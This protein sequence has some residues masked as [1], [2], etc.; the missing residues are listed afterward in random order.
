MRVAEWRPPG[1]L[2]GRFPTGVGLTILDLALPRGKLILMSSLPRANDPRLLFGLIQQWRWEWLRDEWNTIGE[3]L[4]G[5]APPLPLPGPNPP[6]T[7]NVPLTLR[8]VL[9][10]HG[11]L[12]GGTLATREMAMRRI[13]RTRDNWLVLANTP[14]CLAQLKTRGGRRALN[15]ANR[16]YFL[17]VQVER[18]ELGRE[19]MTP[20]STVNQAGYGLDGWGSVGAGRAGRDGVLDAPPVTNLRTGR[21]ADPRGWRP[22]AVVREAFRAGVRPN[23]WVAFGWRQVDGNGNVR[24][25]VPPWTER[26]VTG[27][28]AEYQEV[29]AAFRRFGGTRTLRYYGRRLGLNPVPMTQGLTL[30]ILHKCRQTSNWI[31]RAVREA[32]VRIAAILQ[33]AQLPDLG[34]SEAF[35]DAGLRGAELKVRE[36]KRHE[37]SLRKILHT[38]R[39]QHFRI[40]NPLLEPRASAIQRQA[41]VAT[42]ATNISLAAAA[43]RGWIPA[44]RARSVRLGG[45]YERVWRM[46][47]AWKAAVT[48]YTMGT[49]HC[50]EVSIY[51]TSMASTWHDVQEMA[52]LTGKEI[53]FYDLDV[54]KGVVQGQNPMAFRPMAQS[55][56]GRGRRQGRS[57]GYYRERSVD[58]DED[59]DEG[60]WDLECGVDVPETY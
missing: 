46:Y 54:H 18:P 14:E 34:Q 53:K 36:T 44:A 1:T 8:E 50:V 16:V 3:L 7:T 47:E 13:Y 11:G 38:V 24:A 39:S 52:D 27:C 23:A 4:T 40:R 35:L 43:W 25:G 41:H 33:L 49:A 5:E 6:P 56:L 22:A 37:L 21:R 60:T 20:I 28:E 9:A 2:E 30:R 45:L 57:T 42:A 29:M 31:K 26:E 19:N 10:D 55:G 17:L 12:L 59:S 32:R 48:L 15:E 58:S 51:D